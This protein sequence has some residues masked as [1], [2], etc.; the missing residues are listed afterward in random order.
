LHFLSPEELKN[1][2]ET[3]KPPETPKTPVHPPDLEARL[4]ELTNDPINSGAVG[5]ELTTKIFDCKLPELRNLSCQYG[6]T[7]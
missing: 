4:D 1:S 6:T 5:G 7:G 2:L 3:P